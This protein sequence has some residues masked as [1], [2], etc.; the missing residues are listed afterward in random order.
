ML[1]LISWMYDHMTSK[2]KYTIQIHIL[3]QTFNT[4][5]IMLQ[6]KLIKLMQIEARMCFREKLY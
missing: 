1:M 6:L 3:A 5:L 4:W 2:E